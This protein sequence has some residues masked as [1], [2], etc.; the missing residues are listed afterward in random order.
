MTNIDNKEQ[1]RAGRRVRSLFALAALVASPGCAAGEGEVEVRAWGE[2]FIED[3]IPASEM[4]DGWAI[5]FSRFEVELTEVSIAGVSLDDPGVLDISEAS[6][7][8][9]QLVGRASVPAEDYEDA[10]FTLAQV[11]IEGTASKDGE[12]KSFAWRFEP[13]THYSDCETV[14]EVPRDG[15]GELQITIHADHLFYDSLVS[16]E[17]GLGFDAVAAA[18]LDADGEVTQE[19]LAATDIGP[20][21]PGNLDIDDMWSFLAAQAQTMGHVDGEGHCHSD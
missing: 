17:P 7:G 4:D 14:T 11:S 2:S 16:E 12:V 15:T 5:A 8:R 13:A 19:E 20:Y 18:D 9:G 1:S 6:D 10:S 3:G 21:D